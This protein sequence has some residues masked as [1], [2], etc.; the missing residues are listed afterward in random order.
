MLTALVLVLAGGGFWGY[1]LIISG[2]RPLLPDPCVT[3]SLN[4]LKPA[5]VVVRVYNGGTIRG[6]AATVAKELKTAGFVIATTGNAEEPIHNTVIIGVSPD[7]PEVQFVASW[8][9][10]AIIRSDG[11]P[12]HSVDILVGDAGNQ[13]T[14]APPASLVIPS[15]QICLPSPTASA[16]P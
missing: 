1:H 11:R 9:D 6:L 14:A 8:F 16:T 7:S 4:E 3:M 15:G 10:E 12:D 13:I 5:N 2:Q